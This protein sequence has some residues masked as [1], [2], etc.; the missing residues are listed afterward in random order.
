[1]IHILMVQQK[2]LTNGLTPLMDTTNSLM[3]MDELLM[4]CQKPLTVFT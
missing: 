3:D 4:D 1:M 2:M